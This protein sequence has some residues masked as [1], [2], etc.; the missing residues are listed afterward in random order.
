MDT[1][2]LLPPMSNNENDP[3][4][5]HH[6]DLFSGYENEQNSYKTEMKSYACT[7]PHE[8]HLSKTPEV[9]DIKNPMYDFDVR[10][11]G[12]ECKTASWSYS[13]KLQKLYVK[14][15]NALTV[16]ASYSNIVAHSPC[17]NL[18]IMLVCSAPQDIHRPIYRCQHDIT[19]DNAHGELQDHIVRCL[20]PAATYIGQT[21]GV[22]FKDRLAMVIKLHGIGEQL[23]TPVSLEFLCQNSC[24][25]IERRATA[26]VFT[27]EDDCGVILGRKSIN[28]KICS[29]PKRDMEKDEGKKTNA[30]GTKRKRD[31]DSSSATVDE[32]PARKL[33]RQ[34]SQSCVRSTRSASATNIN[35]HDSPVP[36]TSAMPIDCIKKETPYVPIS[37]SSSTISNTTVE[38]D[39][40]AIAVNLR[41]PDIG[42]AVEVVE[43]AFKHISADM[44]RCGDEEKR[45][46]LAKFLA[47]CRRMKSKYSQFL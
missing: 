42:T 36:S 14:K 25:T 30:A 21:N 38:N 11:E 41:L 2:E 34:M 16:Y 33:T 18:R 12:Q 32:Q 23:V 5:L 29:C 20:N 24:P 7:A 4:I 22:A 8:D 19:K 46:R 47:H 1:K 10:M 43:Y 35:Q 37:R 15:K 6:L 45:N 17:L 3:F 44:V 13:E 26:L 39:S 9:K 31:A 27:L 40:T 28:V